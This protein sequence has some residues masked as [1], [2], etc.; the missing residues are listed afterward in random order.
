MSV[1]E[2]QKLVKTFGKTRAV[3]DISFAVDE[4]EIFGFLGPNGAGKTTTIRCLMDFLRPTSGSIKILGKESCCESLL[5]KSKIGYLSGDV[6]LIGSWTGEEHIKYVEGIRGKKSNA[7][8]IASKLSLNLKQK[9]KNLSSGNKQKLGLV[10]ALGFSPELIIMDEPT[11]GLDPLLQNMIYE[12]LEDAQKQGTTIFMS[13]H[14]LGEVDRLCDR[15]G[16]IRDGK[17]V[18]IESI[19]ELKEKRMHVVQATF[20]SPYNIA[21]FNLPNVEIRHRLENSLILGVKGDINP[22]FQTL[23][24]YNLR[25][26][27]TTH[28]TLEEIFLEFYGRNHLAQT[29]VRPTIDQRNINNPNAVNKQDNINNNLTDI[30]KLE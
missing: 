19:Q 30:P 15:V 3:D 21:D 8:E 26:V 6:R 1:I 28:A 14:N 2:I 18:A 17:L 4:G 23:A 11:V 9:F 12:I 20:N 29:T 16:I 24:K 13:S 7:E 27:E 10:L 22:L 5:A 25:E